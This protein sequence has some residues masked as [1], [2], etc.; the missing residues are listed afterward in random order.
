QPPAVVREARKQ[1]DGAGVKLAILDTG[2]FKV[3]LPESPAKL[4]EQW[5]LLDRAFS[6]A[7]ILGTDLIRTFAFTYP[8]GGS[9]AGGDYPRSYDLVAQAA[10]KARKAGFRF[11]VENVGGSYV[12]TSM[13]SEKLLAAIDNPALGL[14]WD[15]NNAAQMGDKEPFPAGYKRLD[16]KR[17]FHV[18]LRDYK[19][20]PDGSAEWCGVGQGEFDHV[21]QIRAMLADGYKGAFS[22][23]THFKID[24]SKAKAS[25]FSMRNLL[26]RIKQV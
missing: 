14:T 20:T 18:H 1:L 5:A 17:I 11:A 10:E 12:G 16:P 7:D 19:R 25:E 13:D 15:P 3:P 24:G 4:D 6:N 21:G 26:E 22:L 2:F 8:K 9:A 23:E